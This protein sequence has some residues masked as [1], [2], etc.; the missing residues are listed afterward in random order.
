MARK[1][2]RYGAVHASV[3]P[4]GDILG[5]RY[6]YVVPLQGDGHSYL[7]GLVGAVPALERGLFPYGGD[8]VVALF[9]GADIAVELGHNRIYPSQCN[10]S[11]A[12]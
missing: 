4:F 5:A 11:V 9:R 2:F 10:G 3:S 6:L 7:S 1:R 12:R 8:A